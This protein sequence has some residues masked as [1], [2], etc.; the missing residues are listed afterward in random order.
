MAPVSAPTPS[1]EPVAEPRAR[2]TI[3]P[4]TPVAPADALAPARERLAAGDAEGALALLT[5]T[6]P[7]EDGEHW[8]LRATIHQALGQPADAVAAWRQALGRRS[9]VPAWW[10]GMGIAQDLVGDAGQARA[11]F[12]RAEALGLEEP[13]L[14]S[15]VKQRLAALS[16]AAGE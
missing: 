6:A 1:P 2:L 11:A 3:E 15:Y 5:A 4:A 13:A 10:V 8:A 7:G 9:D 16:A 14:A 12:E